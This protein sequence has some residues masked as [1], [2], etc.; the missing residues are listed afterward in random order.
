MKK[1]ITPILLA[2]IALSSPAPAQ[3]TEEQSPPSEACDQA[4]QSSLTRIQSIKNLKV[5]DSGRYESMPE[6]APSG[7]TGRYYVYL[8]GRGGVDLMKSPKLMGTIAENIIKSCNATI[9][10]F[11]QY[12]SAY[13]ITFGIFEDG[14]IRQFK[15]MEDEYPDFE[16]RSGVKIPYGYS[17][18][19]L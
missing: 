18:C 2:A 19:N 12:R 9:F 10:T 8:S 13:G 16:P 17:V 6:G 15:C 3:A 11:G 7:S 1:L 5:E 14:V 4:M